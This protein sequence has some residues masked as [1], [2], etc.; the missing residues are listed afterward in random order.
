MKNAETICTHIKPQLYDHSV[1]LS[2]AF[3]AVQH[4]AG[5]IPKN[6]LD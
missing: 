5:E 6:T 2:L 3:E 4:A 1:P